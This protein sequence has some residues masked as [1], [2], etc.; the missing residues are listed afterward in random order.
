MAITKLADIIEPSIYLSYDKEFLPEK[1]ALL[2]EAQILAPPPPDVMSQ[3]TAG[4]ATID[5]PFW[6]DVAR[7]EPNILSD[8]E[9]SLAVP[10]KIGTAEEIA[11]KHFWHESWSSMR[12]AGII[13]T[14]NQ[15]D[16]LKAVVEFTSGYWANVMITTIIKSFDGLITD[17]IDNDASDM[18]YDIYSDIATPLAANKISP[19]AVNRARFTMG[20]MMNDLTAIVMHSKVY[21]D[22]L[23]QEA[24]DFVQPSHLPFV[25]PKFAG[26]T[27][28][29]SDDVTVTSGANT[30]MY[31][32]I[33]FGPGAIA[34]TVHL[35]ED[36]VETEREPRAG[37][38]GGQDI[39]HNRRHVL[40]HP[41]GFA[42]TKASMAGKS[43]TQAEMILAT[44]WNR[45]G[46]RKNIRMCSLETN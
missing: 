26:A 45:V 44:N 17:N 29:V 15:N 14:G 28:I 32:S 18:V 46:Q 21:T 8:D 19:A 37:D 40:V 30:P 16:P 43:P 34:H 2:R 4:G 38:G 6:Q 20:E 39:L 11:I 9:T 1:Q 13:A 35:P 24:I 31:R 3:M 42:F 36:A 23:D 33:L 5:M 12:L 25:I 7:G 41:R 27:V 10:K 22:A